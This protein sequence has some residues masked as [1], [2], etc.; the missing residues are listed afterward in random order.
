MQIKKNK[1][2]IARIMRTKI[3]FA[4]PDYAA[5]LLWKDNKKPY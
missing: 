1:G 2:A 5:D 4:T 3:Y